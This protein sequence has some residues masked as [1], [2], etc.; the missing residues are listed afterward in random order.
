M[1]VQ[2][3][4]DQAAILDTVVVISEDGDIRDLL[5]GEIADMSV[6]DVKTLLT[7]S[8]DQWIFF[9]NHRGT[10]VNDLVAV[11]ADTGQVQYIVN[12]PSGLITDV[13]GAT[14]C[15]SPTR[16]LLAMEEAGSGVP[17]VTVIEL[18]TKR[19]IRL[20]EL[21][22]MPQYQAVE[23]WSPD[24]DE[25]KLLF[26]GWSGDPRGFPHVVPNLMTWNTRE[27]TQQCLVPHVCHSAWSPDGACIAFF[28]VG[29]P[30]YDGQ[31]QLI[32]TS[33]AMSSTV[34]LEL[35]IL[36]VET[37]H[38]VGLVPASLAQTP[39]LIHDPRCLT[40]ILSWSPDSS[41]LVYSTGQGELW[42]YFVDTRT[43][44]QLMPYS[45]ASRAVWSPDGTRVAVVTPENILI[46]EID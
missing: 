27:G 7:W 41:K 12:Y 22:E 26:E 45:E 15:W 8:D 24:S 14:Y 43:R 36:D 16:A 1:L 2:P 11:H 40:N 18:S 17:R 35:G 4:Q 28:L 42:L 6:S 31:G 30:I 34:H 9:M 20:Y 13:M 10:G 25:Q 29:V 5:P 44:Q 38:I 23:G 39:K 37:N 21:P 3:R 19:Q 32:D 33:V 46:L